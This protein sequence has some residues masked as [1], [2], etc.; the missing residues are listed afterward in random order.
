MRIRS[1]ISKLEEE[2]NVSNNEV[3]CWKLYLKRLFVSG[4]ITESDVKSLYNLPFRIDK[5]E[6]EGHI[7]I[8]NL[9]MDMVSDDVKKEQDNSLI[10][11][12]KD[13]VAFILDGTLKENFEKDW[14]F[15][16]YEC[17]ND[18]LITK[19]K[20]NLY[21]TAIDFNK[22]LTTEEEILVQDI[23]NVLRVKLIKRDPDIIAE[24]DNPSFDMLMAANDIT[25]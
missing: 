15:Y 2:K 20:Y 10:K 3:I 11:M 22:P 18:K 17:L 25:S 7:E 24:M 14:L 19:E 13:D 8:F 23:L 16:L 9:I 4:E 1:R 12:V 6:E 5:I 21:K